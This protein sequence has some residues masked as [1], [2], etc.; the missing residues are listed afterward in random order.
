MVLSIQGVPRTSFAMN[1][2]LKPGAQTFRPPNSYHNCWLNLLPA[3]AS[4]FSGIEDVHFFANG[5]IWNLTIQTGDRAVST[6]NLLAYRR[7]AIVRFD[8]DLFQRV[9]VAD[10]DCAVG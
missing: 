1:G 5:E 9:P 7:Q 4:V 6:A 8:P 10:G 2:T 3:V